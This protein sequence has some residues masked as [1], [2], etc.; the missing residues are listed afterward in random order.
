MNLLAEHATL[1]AVVS[2][3]AHPTADCTRSVLWAPVVA[4]EVTSTTT[5]LTEASVATSTVLIEAAFATAMVLVEGSLAT[6]TV[7][8]EASLTI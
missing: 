1:V 2:R 7:L 8:I 4:V 3:V 5:V 6:A